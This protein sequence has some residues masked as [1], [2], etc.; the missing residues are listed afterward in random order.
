MVVIVRYS[1]QFG[2]YGA[3]YVKVV[4]DRSMLFDGNVVQRI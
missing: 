4:K 2:M 1:T 3:S